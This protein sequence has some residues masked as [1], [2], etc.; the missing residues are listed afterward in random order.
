[1]TGRPVPLTLTEE[2]GRLEVSGVVDRRDDRKWRDGRLRRRFRATTRRRR[3]RA[4]RATCAVSRGETYPDLRHLAV[5][6]PWFDRDLVRRLALL[7][8]RSRPR[9]RWPT[10]PHPRHRPNPQPHRSPLPRPRHR[11]S[12]PRSR[13]PRRPPRAGATRDR[14]RTRGPRGG[15]EGLRAVD[16]PAG[17]LHPA[18]LP[19]PREDAG[20]PRRHRRLPARARAHHRDR[21][22]QD[23]QP[24]HRQLLRGRAPAAVHAVRRVP[25]DQ[26]RAAQE[27]VRVAR[28]RP[29]PRP[30]LAPAAAPATPGCR[31][32]RRA[33]SARS[34]PTAT[35]ARGSSPRSATSSCGSARSTARV[36]TSARTR[37]TASSTRAGSRSRRSASR[38]RCRRPRSPASSCRSRYRSATTRSATPTS[39]RS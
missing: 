6:Q 1:M 21:R 15:A 26:A 27:R 37:T 31:S 16:V 12:R 24:R 20:H 3:R 2:R 13:R 23:R 11:R 32:S 38:R 34:L 36:A 7:I 30:D 18:R 29:D 39:P 4:A 19:A 17:R 10:S 33:R 8:L 14:G 9:R 25:H 28:P 5:T 22:R 35:S